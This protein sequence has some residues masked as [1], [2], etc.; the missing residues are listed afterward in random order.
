M[1]RPVR[2]I[3]AACAACLL[4]ASA[5]ASGDGDAIRL[6]VAVP[7][8]T[9]GGR[10]VQRGVTL[11]VEEFN[12][13]G[14]V[15]GRRV[16]LEVRDDGGESGRAIAVAA[17]LRD[18]PRVAAVIGH[19]NSSTTLAAAGVYNDPRDGVLE[20][21]PT[22][23]SPR[24]SEAGPWTFRV[25]P[26]DL[27]YGPAIARWLAGR[28]VKRAAVLYLND[29]YG[30]PLAESFAAAF[31]TGGGTV[32]SR[33]PFLPEALADDE[34]VSAYLARAMR[35]GMEALVI[36]GTA[37]DARRIVPA[38]RR[39]GH[40]GI[41][42]GADGLLGME[43]FGAGVDGTYLGAAF[44]AD[45]RSAPAARFVRAYRERWGEL[46]NADGALAYD[47]ARVVLR[48]LAEGG[49]GRRQVRDYVAGIGTATPPHEGA[50]GSIRFDANGDAADKA[51]AVGV[52]RDRRVSAA[53]S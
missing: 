25:S 50:T 34:A 47:A 23:S 26:T 3:L 53:E 45:S 5:C 31:G 24:L 44:F 35:R 42:I 16:E 14:G 6:G 21:S 38:A 9:T 36:G 48:A 13:A 8:E 12:A 15:D 33:D 17:E 49:T 30:R 18:D 2:P 46:P 28:G 51:V 52:V 11:A 40:R 29:E 7:A 22:A 4:L 32:V 10:S 1:P 43:E 19:V 37:E 27:A 39:A 20:I 41:I